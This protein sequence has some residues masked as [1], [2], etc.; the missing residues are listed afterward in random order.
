MSLTSPQFA[1]YIGI[2]YSGAQTAD[3]SLKGLRAYL[4]HR[5]SP[6]EEALPPLG[7][8]KHWS[9][10]GLA[11]W[12]EERLAEDIPTIVGI[13]HAFSF[14]RQYFEAHKLPHDW[15]AFLDD[16]QQHWP[17][18]EPNISVEQVRRG[19]RGQGKQREGSSR[20]RRLCEQRCRA[21][22]V[23]HFDVPGS[24]AKSSHAGIP[25]LRYLR[26]Q[27][28]ERVHFW[29]FDG[30]TISPG[31]SAIAEIYPALWSHAYP[32][33]DRTPD[34]HDAYVVASWLR[35]ADRDGRLPQALQPNSEAKAAGLEIEG[36]IL[37]VG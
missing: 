26:R 27:L 9:R 37:G 17:T 21:K 28:G 30:W 7:T 33:Q 19:V 34:Q 23:F 18:D 5:D 14:P 31:R 8:R 32:R 29:S 15:P 25:W 22:S 16:F 12:L 1:R 4:T 11:H 10:R 20:W 24:V 3:D 13:D 6:A 36:W 2:D 35:D